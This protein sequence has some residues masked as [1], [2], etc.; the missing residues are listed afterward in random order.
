MHINK[1]IILRVVFG[2]VF[3]AI[4]ARVL[5]PILMQFL[6][7]KMPGYYE[8]EKDID[9]LIKRQK[10]RFRSQYGLGGIDP[11]YYSGTSSNTSHENLSNEANNA[12]AE[13]KEIYQESKWGGGA[14]VKE[15]Q[16]EITKNYSYTVAESKIQN[17]ISLV[18]RKKYLNFL[19]DSNRSSKNSIKNFLLTLFVLFS[20]SD[21]IREKK[22]NL[23]SNIARK[24]NLSEFELALALQ[25]KMLLLIAPK[26]NLKEDRIYADNY[27]LNQYA[28]D[29][30]NEA[31]ELIAKKEAN[32]WAKSPSMLFEELSLTLN[33]ASIMAPTP[34]ILNRKDIANAYLVLGVT[35]DQSLDEIK[36]VY[37]KIAL[38][39]HPDKIVSQK[40]PKII[41]RKAID[42][43]NKIQEAL[44]IIVENKK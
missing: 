5:L 27:V 2:F 40:L 16:Q 23:L 10:E 4:C 29:T 9:V 24:L 38:Q 41:E 13:M 33:F 6:K 19:N 8:Q 43:F 39:K 3:V 22:F 18:E 20:I 42:K 21:E 35:K 15:I 12:T 34:K 14:V 11:K 30:F 37:K 7:S 26:K 32:L 31:R 25:M 36:K 28:E 17:F 1:D 44:E